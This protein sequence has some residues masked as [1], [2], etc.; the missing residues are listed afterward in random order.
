MNYDDRLSPRRCSSRSFSPAR[1]PAAGPGAAASQPPSGARY[2]P[3]RSRSNT[4]RWTRSS[5]TPQGTLRPRSHQGRLPGLRGRQAA[6][7]HRVRAAS[8]FPSSAPSGRSSRRAPSSPTC[9]Q[10][11]GRSTAACTCWCSTTCT[12]T[13]CG[14]PQRVK[15]AA[16]Q[17]I[18]RNLGANDLMAVVHDRRPQRRRRRSSPA[19]SGCCSRRSTSSWAASSSRPRSTRNERILPPARHAPVGGRDQRSRTIRARVQRPVRRCGTLKNV[20]D[21]FG[22]VRGRRKTMLLHQRR[23]RL[24]HHRH[25]PRLRLTRPARRIG[26]PRRHP[27]QRSPPTARSNVAS[28]RIDPRGLTAIGRRASIGSLAAVRRRARPLCASGSARC[29]ERAAA[30]AG[31][32]ADARRRNRR[33]R[34]GQ[35]ERFTTAFERIVSDNSSYYVLAYYP[36]D[37][38]R[39]GKLPQDRGARDSRPGMTVRSRRGY[40]AP[41]EGRPGR[42][43]GARAGGVARSDGGAR[44]ARFRSA[45]STMRVF[46]APFKGDRAECVGAARRRD[47][48]AATSARPRTRKVELSYFAI[49]AKARSRGGDTDALTMP[50][51]GRKPRPARRADRLAH[52]QPPRAAARHAISCASPRTT[53]SGAHVG[54][55]MLRSRGARLPQG[56]VRISGLVLTSMS[57]SAM[58]TARRRRA[59]AS[60]PAGPPIALRTFP[61]NDEIALFAEVYDNAGSDAAQGR[62]RHDG[63]ER[64]TAR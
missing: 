31:Q 43:A 13:R 60:S 41:E 47:A 10:R 58:L 53:S 32:P 62:H 63:H 14:P 4:S 25:H 3:S 51:C 16:R 21:W 22:G 11:D 48:R 20:A 8:T 45:A 23:D 1:R 64:T 44:T 17:F 37:D 19:T 34:G 12:P 28:T 46:A 59:A 30:V 18:E 6:D 38:K 26:D 52:A 54:S 29:D 56:A 40:V 39:D 2:R 57:G 36:P 7:D 61:Q 50:T 9:Q 55:V 15:K 33:L 35:H 24:R 42:N 49:D 27:R 5:P